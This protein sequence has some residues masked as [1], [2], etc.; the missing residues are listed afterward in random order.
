[1]EG[2]DISQRSP[3]LGSVDRPRHGGHRHPNHAKWKTRQ[4]CKKP[5]TPHGGRVQG[6]CPREGTRAGQQVAILGISYSECFKCRFRYYLGHVRPA[7]QEVT[8]AA[9][10]GC[11]SVSKGRGRANHATRGQGSATTSQRQRESGENVGERL[12]VVSEKEQARRQQ[13][14]EDWLV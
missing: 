7:G 10:T 4:R 9:K 8:A 1:M 3:R 13:Q 12:D 11:Y 6:D 5:S 2:T 14:V